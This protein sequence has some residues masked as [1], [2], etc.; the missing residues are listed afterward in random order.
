M[1]YEIHAMAVLTRSV[2]TVNRLTPWETSYFK[3]SF[4]LILKNCR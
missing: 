4:K 2:G 3:Y 1:F